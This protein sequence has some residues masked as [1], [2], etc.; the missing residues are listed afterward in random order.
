MSVDRVW[1]GTFA[2]CDDQTLQCSCVTYEPEIIIIIIQKL[3]QQAPHL[4]GA[5][6]SS[7]Q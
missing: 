3:V 4:S 7:P 5:C 2:L 1:Q 6:S